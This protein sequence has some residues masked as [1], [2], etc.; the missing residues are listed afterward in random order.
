ML[1]PNQ[2]SDAALGRLDVREAR[3]E[4]GSVG[5]MLDVKDDGCEGD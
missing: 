1:S 5:G 2:E 3:C 4:G